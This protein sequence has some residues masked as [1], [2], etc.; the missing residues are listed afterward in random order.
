MDHNLPISIGYWLAALAPLA[1]LLI[2]LVVLEWSGPV[3]GWLALLLAVISGY[4]LFDTPLDTLF[5]GG[6]KG[7]WDA[8]FVL[9]VVWTALLLYQVSAK[10]DAFSTIREGVLTFSK[11]YLFITLAFGWVFASFLQGVA[12]FGAP[13]AVVAPLLV[14]IGV[15]PVFAVV[16]PLIGHNWA[17]MFGSLGVSWLATVQIVDIENQM[18]AAVLTSILLWIL[19]FLAGLFITYLYGKWKGVKEGLPM[20]LIISGIHGIGQVALSMINPV[21]STFVPS[22]IA[23]GAL[24]FLSNWNRYSEKSNVETNILKEESE[25]QEEGESVLSLMDAVL[26]YIV[27]TVISIIGLAIPSITEFLEQFSISFGF[28][29]VTTGYDYT[30]AAT[31]AYSPL[32]FLTHPGFYILV[33][34]IFGYVWYKAKGAYEKKSGSLGNILKGLWEEAQGTTIS[35]IGFLVMAQILE[36]SGQTP[37]LAL[38]IAA[39]APPI[40]Y[41]ALT[42]WIGVVGAFM[43]SSNTSSNILLAPL[44]ASVATSMEGL[45]LELAIAGQSAG[46]ALGNV[47]AP[48]NIVLGASTAG[49][50]GQTSDIL[51][52][53]LRYTIL[54]GIIISL[55]IIGLFLVSPG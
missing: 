10:A 12:G 54:S 6:G 23:M 32:T 1:A 51:K 50:D 21:L 25:S 17:N 2:M 45:G 5:V 55:V 7:I 18:L 11:N 24:Y 53:T 31:E 8:L 9:L 47:V 41:A 33:S 29:E 40:V 4:F 3:S 43:T 30:V 26:P 27:L 22:I 44:H 38:G 52:Y 28:P 34:A 49:I 48:A 14:G 15:K 16:I 13:I 20:V 19:N 42:N 36:H 37:V 46:G 39:V 35:I